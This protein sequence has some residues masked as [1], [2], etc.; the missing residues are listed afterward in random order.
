MIKKYSLLSIFLALILSLFAC[1][2]TPLEE[3]EEKV[4]PPEVEETAS[5]E[6]DTA[7]V[8]EEVV[9]DQ[10]DPQGFLILAD[11]LER[12]EPYVQRFR[13]FIG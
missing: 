6:E 10:L 4:A 13:H 3:T 2:G 12:G 11:K 5:P 9:Y 1:G 8:E 7:E